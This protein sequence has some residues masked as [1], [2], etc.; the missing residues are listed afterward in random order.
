MERSNE[1]FYV[2]GPLPCA[3][4]HRPTV[5]ENEELYCYID[6]ET[7]KQTAQKDKANLGITG[8]CTEFFT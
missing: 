8:L 4:N 7:Q 2:N 3:K 5:S 1:V 6:R